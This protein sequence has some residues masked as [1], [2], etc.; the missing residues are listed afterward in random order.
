[1]PT[2][3]GQQPPHRIRRLRS[4]T[5]PV[6]CP[7]CIELDVFE[8]LATATRLGFGDGVVSAED[9]DGFAVTSGSGVDEM[10]ALDVWMC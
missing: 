3:H 2:Y 1:M 5:Q 8:R 6:F 9:F 4:N 7:C 10:S